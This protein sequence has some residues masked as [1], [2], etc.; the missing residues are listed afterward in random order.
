MAP[1]VSPETTQGQPKGGLG[2][3]AG[4]GGHEAGQGVY[5]TTSRSQAQKYATGEG[6]IGLSK[7]RQEGRVIEFGIDE[8]AKIFD[9]GDEAENSV[10]FSQLSQDP[11]FT[12]WWNDNYGADTPKT[13][14]NLW[15]AGYEAHLPIQD[16]LRKQGYQ[17]AK[18]ITWVTEDQ[19]HGST[20]YAIWDQ[21][22]IK[23]DGGIK[24][25]RGQPKGGQPAAIP[26]PGSEAF[27]EA[28]RQIAQDND[29]PV[30]EI[31]DD[32][33]QEYLAP[34]VPAQS[35]PQA[36]PPAAGG[37]PASSAGGQAT[38]AENTAGKESKEN[39][40]QV[41]QFTGDKRN[42]RYNPQG[43]TDYALR[44][45]YDM[46]Q[47]GN[48]RYVFGTPNGWVI[49]KD[50]PPGSQQYFKVEP[51]GL[52]TAHSPILGDSS[53]A[54]AEGAKARRREILRNRVENAEDVA[55]MA[56][57]LEE[58]RGEPWADAALAK[59]R[60]GT[61]QS[62]VTA[63]TQGE[64]KQPWEMTLLEYGKSELPESQ[65]AQITDPRQ[66]KSFSAQHIKEI[67]GA[68]ERGDPVPRAVLEEYRGQPWADAAL[69]K[70]GER[71]VYYAHLQ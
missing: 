10:L 60:E 15:D 14:K 47:D 29:L 51:D 31:T 67:K 35:A 40:R 37:V 58:F 21:S 62:Q 6:P 2:I 22:I 46:T 61:Q 49:S 30:D 8:N 7:P 69:A 57:S 27:E 1:A 39:V 43:S 19:P 9:M 25:F 54:I 28:R 55:G 18:Y 24:V 48:P 59:L 20:D 12:K 56:R 38:P 33:V 32:M 66:V 26:E 36:Q 3:V 68:L 65:R 34:Q 71:R 44:A 45:A 4:R 41:S 42:R 5:A 53:D 50:Q 23:R 52:A 17:G 16:I 63:G 13:N 70:L 11:K 64:A